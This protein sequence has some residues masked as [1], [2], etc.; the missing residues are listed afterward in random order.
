MRRIAMVVAI[1]LV[2]C[3][4]TGAD[5]NR[6]VSANSPSAG[7]EPAAT[8]GTSTA[9][10]SESLPPFTPRAASK[11]KVVAHSIAAVNDPEAR[12]RKA[13]Q[14]LAEI[15]EGRL[16]KPALDAL[17]AAADRRVDLHRRGDIAY[18]VV[19]ETVELRNAWNHACD[20]GRF[21]DGERMLAMLSVKSLP[22]RDKTTQLFG[23]CRLSRRGLVTKPEQLTQEQ[24]M[25]VLAHTIHAFLEQRG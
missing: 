21:G 10:S 6:A 25:M 8:E 14:Y 20:P 7:S 19:T 15:E 1:L 2:G 18:R 22:D 23:R 12:L 3:Q 24:D 16:P 5:P 11:A 9:A 4:S 13:S 17:S